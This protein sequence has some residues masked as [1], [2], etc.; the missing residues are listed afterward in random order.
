MRSFRNFSAA[1]IHVLVKTFVSVPYLV[2]LQWI[3]VICNQDTNNGV[4][5]KV[6]NNDNSDNKGN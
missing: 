3:T 6:Y 4:L 1:S 2:Q 5:E